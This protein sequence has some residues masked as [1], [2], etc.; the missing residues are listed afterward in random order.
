MKMHYKK[1]F[2]IICLIFAGTNGIQFWVSKGFILAL[3]L[4]IFGIAIGVLFFT[5]TYFVVNDD[6]LVLHPLLHP[7]I[8][9]T[10]T[11]YKFQSIKEIETDNKGIFLVQNGN[12]Q[13]INISAWMVD[14]S[15]WQAFLQKINSAS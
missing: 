9:P 2:G 1:V 11:T 5:R 13:K 4:G 14:E 10:K 15:D 7:F 3:I 12:R 8:G 6:S